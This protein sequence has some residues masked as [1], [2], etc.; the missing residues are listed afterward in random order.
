MIE[1]HFYPIFDEDFSKSEIWILN[2][3]SDSVSDDDK[4][5]VSDSLGISQIRKNLQTE[6]PLT[7]FRWGRHFRLNLN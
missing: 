4:K 1:H 2:T 3:V 5:N 7:L 6:L